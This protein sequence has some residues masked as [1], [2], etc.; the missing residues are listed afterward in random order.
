MNNANDA[1]AGDM[2]T[3]T[4]GA[5]NARTKQQQKLP[6]CVCMCIKCVYGC[7]CCLSLKIDLSRLYLV[8]LLHNIYRRA[9]R[10]RAGTPYTYI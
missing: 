1:S 3:T 8:V 9:G 7:Y 6:V 4:R 2:T 5:R 10:R